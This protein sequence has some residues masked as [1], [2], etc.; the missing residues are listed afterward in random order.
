MKVLKIIMMII[1]I[2]MKPQNNMFKDFNKCV[3][4]PNY[5]QILLFKVMD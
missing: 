4:P 3:D 2:A 5:M 1:S